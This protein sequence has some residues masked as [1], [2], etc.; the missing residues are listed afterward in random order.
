[1]EKPNQITVI[2]RADDLKRAKEFGESADLRQAM[3]AAGVVGPPDVR[4]LN[5]T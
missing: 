3:Q 5:E 2:L 4:F 1:V